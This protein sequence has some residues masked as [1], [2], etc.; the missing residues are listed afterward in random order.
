MRASLDGAVPSPHGWPRVLRDAGLAEV[1]T[2]SFLFEAGPP[3]EPAQAAFVRRHLEDSL[4]HVGDLLD[5]PDRLALERLCDPD[6]PACA[7]QR[8]DV[9]VLTAE[10]VHFGV[11]PA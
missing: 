7:E 6:D 3:L 2:R 11:R 8:D 1:R 9:F 4:E 5:E 10:S